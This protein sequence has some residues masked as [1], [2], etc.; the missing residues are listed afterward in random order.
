MIS[1]AQLTP[2]ADRLR[3]ILDDEPRRLGAAIDAGAVRSG[4]T[5]SIDQ[6][7]R[8]EAPILIIEK[9]RTRR[10]RVWLERDVRCRAC[11]TCL[12][13]RAREW[14]FRMQSELGEA[15]RTWFGT[16][17]LSPDNHQFFLEL[18]RS[19]LTKRGT[20]LETLPAAEQF[21]VRCWAISP[22]L[23]RFLK[24]VRKVSNAPL[25]YILVAE[26]HKSGLPHYHMLIHESD[27]SNP[28]RHAQLQSNWALGYS[29]WKLVEDNSR[30]AHYAAKYLAKSASA[31][32]RASLRYGKRS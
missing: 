5:L 2:N 18:A 19:R 8:C 28:V 22:E 29:S 15:E 14:R 20:D 13:N 25:R 24:R 12:K 32:V 7:G 31:R 16:M 10:Q 3:I 21:Q 27:P 6:G 4:Q 11:K 1:V 17:T 9:P 26:P 23:T 30:A